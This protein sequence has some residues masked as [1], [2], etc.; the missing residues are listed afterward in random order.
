MKKGLLALSLALTL[1]A[2]SS[3]AAYGTATGEIETI[4]AI[5]ENSGWGAGFNGYTW[6]S[7]KGQSSIGNC[8]ASSKNGLVR[9]FIGP[10]DHHIVSLAISAKLSG[11]PVSIDWDDSV[12]QATGECI[13]RDI[14]LN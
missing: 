12:K 1:P 13:A 2:F 11:M 8:P 4:L 9:F 5:S 14:S 10:N 3:Y 7:L 6:V